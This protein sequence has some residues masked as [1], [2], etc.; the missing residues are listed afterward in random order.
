MAEQPIKQ[1]VRDDIPVIDIQKTARQ[2]IRVSHKYWKG[3]AYVDARMYVVGEDGVYV[4][5]QRGISIRHEHLAPVIQGLL[6]ASRE[7]GQGGCHE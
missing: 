5:T 1:P 7:V 2:R 6:Q 3:I 4:P